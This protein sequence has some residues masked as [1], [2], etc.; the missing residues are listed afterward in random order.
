MGTQ[1]GVGT[2]HHR[3]PVMAGKEAAGQA[4]KQAGIDRPDW[5]M[6]FATVGYRQQL[7]LKSVRETT[8]HAPLVGCSGGGI[9]AQG[10]ADESNFAVSVMVLKSDE[11]R[12]SHGLE[13]GFKA[14]SVQVGEAVGTAI[15]AAA[16]QLDVVKAMFL[17]TDG[18]A[19]NFD[20]FMVG[21]RDRTDLEQ[22]IPAIGCF[23]GD[24][25][26]YQETFQYYDDQVVTDGAV[27]ALLSGEALLVSA[28]SHGCE[29]L[30]AKHVVTKSDRNV[31]YEVD[32]LPVLQVLESYLTKAEID[33]WGSAA[34]MVAWGFNAPDL[35][36]AEQLPTDEKL[37]RC[38]AAKN[39]ETGEISFFTDIAEGSEF[40]IVR[41]DAQKIF[42]KSEEMAIALKAQLENPS[43]DK[44]P[45]LF[46]HVECVGR[47]KLILR[48][49][50]KLDLLEGLQHKLGKDIPWI[51]L[52]AFAEIGPAAGQNRFHNLTSILTAIC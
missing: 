38:M 30:G 9:I 18:L 1:V 35:A 49:R 36:Q 34:V 41:R 44:A 25:L 48:D 13:T 37:I 4:L 29:S 14:S 3:N 12:F 28:I 16:E 19:P 46:F 26:S 40:W 7:L 23:A 39:D 52:Y 50:E 43:V 11:M 33:H 42:E 6:M 24:N 31:V 47:G 27:W 5:V 45:K 2:S 8:G 21:L 10:V 17:F 51:G 15:S 22:T 20:E 32:N